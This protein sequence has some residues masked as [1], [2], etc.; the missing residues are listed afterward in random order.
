M[1]DAVTKISSE[2]NVARSEA[3][4]IIATLL[5]KP[6]FELY[7]NDEKDPGLWE[8]L[9]EKVVLLKKGVPIEYITKRAQFMDYTITITPGVFI[10]RLETEYFVELIGRYKNKPATILEIGTG[11]GC[12]A[13]ALAHWFPHC[14]FIATDISDEALRCAEKNISTFGL[15]HRIS[16]VKTDVCM[17]LHTQFDMIISNPPYV[18]HTRLSSLPESVKCYEPLR[19]LNGGKNGI[20]I[21]KKIVLQG[22]PLLNDGGMIALEIDEETT[23]PLNEFLSGCECPSWTFHKD[24][25]GRMRYMFIGDTRHEKSTHCR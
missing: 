23:A 8:Q 15:E 13:I 1:K 18:P 7:L 20:A 9:Q 17:G 21:I 14:R 19:A 3:E 6:R 11:S 10:P 25:F 4:L 5:D 22:L 24:L 16:L 12:L 2:L